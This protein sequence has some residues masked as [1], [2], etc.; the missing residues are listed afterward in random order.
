MSFTINF[1]FPRGIWMENIEWSNKVIKINDPFSFDIKELKDLQK[2]IPGITEIWKYY[3]LNE[4]PKRIN[5]I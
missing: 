2:K 5:L 4:Y 1:V 3:H